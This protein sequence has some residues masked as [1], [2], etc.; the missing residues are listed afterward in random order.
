MQ[1]EEYLCMCVCV[2]AFVHVCVCVCTL[3]LA[4]MST[5][6]S[7]VALIQETGLDTE[8]LATL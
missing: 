2:C 8:T 5:L 6:F 3:S 4:V 7:A 1:I